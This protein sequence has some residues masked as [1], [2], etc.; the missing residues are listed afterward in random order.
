MKA[1]IL[2]DGLLGTELAK[3]T[4]WDI[5]SRKIG[6][7]NIR[8]FQ[9]YILDDYEVII[10][11]IANTDTY[12][13]ID[14]GHKQVNFI[15]P[16]NLSDY[17]CHKGIKL[18]HISTEFVYA[19]NSSSASEDDLPIPH[20]SYYAKFKLLADHYISLTNSN[21]LICRLLHKPYPF[22]YDKV[23]NVQTSG[24]TVDKIAKLVIKLIEKNA[25]GIINVGTGKKKL[26]EI[27]PDREEIDAPGNVPLDTSMSLL[28]QNSILDLV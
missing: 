17:C 15:F 11:C 18:V 7:F 26:K 25:T 6:N 10:N 23:W 14:I 20:D 9:S 8:E 5:L 16:S 12:S 22:P 27:A 28:K 2:G 1:A 19:G 24:D 13:K 4:G 3:L 21:Y